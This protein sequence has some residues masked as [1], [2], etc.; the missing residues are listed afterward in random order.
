MFESMNFQKYVIAFFTLLLLIALIYLGITVPM[1][2][3]DMT[4]SPIVRPC[5]DYWVDLPLSSDIK[6]IPGQRCINLSGATGIS[7]IPDFASGITGYNYTIKPNSNAGHTG[8]N[9]GIYPVS[10][11]N[12]ISP[13][14]ITDV[15]G[16]NFDNIYQAPDFTT[17]PYVGFQ[18]FCAKHNWAKNNGISWDGI[19]YGFGATTHGENPCS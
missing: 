11:N 8:F 5:P 18:G 10:S 7:S 12:G 14:Y 6:Y 1:Q 3:V 9:V 13:S 19:T 17:A 15:N 4:W 2:Q 16:N